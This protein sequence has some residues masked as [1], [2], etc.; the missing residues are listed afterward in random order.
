MHIERF[1]GRRVAVCPGE[2]REHWKANPNQFFLKLQ[3]RGA[4]FDE[5]SIPESKGNNGW[6]YLG[7]YVLVGLIFGAICAYVAVT[8]GHEATGWF[9]AGLVLNVIGL[10][11]VL[12]KGQGDLSKYPAGVPV[13]FAKV[14]STYTPVVCQTCGGENHPSASI[15]SQ[16]GAEQKSTVET[17][18]SK[19]S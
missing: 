7:M 16:C 9:L 14:P 17:E 1:K 18:A 10:I 12:V 4:L 19:L 13:G 3:S 11:A 5:N 15:C 8:Q 6:L 2:C